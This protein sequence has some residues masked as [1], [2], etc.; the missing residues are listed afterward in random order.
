MILT[1]GLREDEPENGEA[2]H[3]DANE[4]LVRISQSFSGFEIQASA[5]QEIFVTKILESKSGYL[6]IHEIGKG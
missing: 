5:C 6:K 4:D 3:A 2:Y 1:F